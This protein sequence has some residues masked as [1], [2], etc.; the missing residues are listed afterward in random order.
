MADGAN[1]ESATMI[2]LAAVTKRFPGSDTPAVD[3]LEACE[4]R[5]DIGDGRHA[6]RGQRPPAAAQPI[7]MDATCQRRTGRTTVRVTHPRCVR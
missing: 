4:L 3:A 5:R 7:T 1:G 6:G 2:R